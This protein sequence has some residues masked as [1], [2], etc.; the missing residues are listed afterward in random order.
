MKIDCPECGARVLAEDLELTSKMAKCRACNAVF[1]FAEAALSTPSTQGELARTQTRAPQPEG[2]TVREESEGSGE[3]GYR[4]APGAG[5]SITLVRRWFT[6]QVV[7]LLFFCIGWD[8]FLFFWY[9]S[10][11]KGSGPFS[12]LMVVFP[13][14][15]VAVGV[16][17]SYY[18]LAGFL[19]RTTFRLDHQAFSIRHAPLPWKGN[20]RIPRDEIT[21]LFCEEVVTQGKNGPSS[22][23]WLSAVLTGERKLRLASMPLDQA[24]FLEE[25]LEEKL[26]LP[27]V[28]VPGEIPRLPG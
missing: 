16:G 12:L 10:A 13:V 9:A 23:Y 4:D 1:S 11:F 6:P 27:D 25:R 8:S 14:A 3:P 15:H 21:Q 20:R 18:T 17:L 7:F 22:T 5:P 28:A 2:I 24:R 26:A 19:N